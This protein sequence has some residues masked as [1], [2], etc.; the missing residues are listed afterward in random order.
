MA[1]KQV[2][3]NDIYIGKT[4]PVRVLFTP[5]LAEAAKIDGKGDPKFEVQIGFDKDHP[6]VLPMKK[7]MARIAKEKWGSDV[8]LKSL[9][10]KFLDGD[11][12]YELSA[13]H[14]IADKRREYPH[15]KGLTIM[16]LR[17]KNPI[18]VFDVRQRNDKGV[19]VEISDSETIR[20]IVYAGAYVSMKLTFATYDGIVDRDPTKSRPPGITVYPEQI[21]FVADGERLAA[22]SKS[23]GSGFAAVQGQVSDENPGVDLDDEIPF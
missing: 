2:Y 18:T 6:D 7:E 4:K 19:P 21:C 20:K 22:G 8:D 23:D 13:N 9:Q 16:K 3:A 15:L 17:S 5:K 11:R 10:L 14:P 1:N 12:E